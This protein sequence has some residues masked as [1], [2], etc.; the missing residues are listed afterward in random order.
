MRK[1]AEMTNSR[2]AIVVPTKHGF[3]GITLNKTPMTQPGQLVKTLSYWMGSFKKLEDLF[4]NLEYSKETSVFID[5]NYQILLPSTDDIDSVWLASPS[6]PEERD[7]TG[8]PFSLKE[9]A[10]LPDAGVLA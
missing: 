9:M 2:I 8:S 10:I 3:S 6:T 4:S 7:R 1:G 5:E